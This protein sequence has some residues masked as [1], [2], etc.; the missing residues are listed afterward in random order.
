MPRAEQL[1]DPLTEHGE[2]PVWF[3][4]PRELRWVD[5]LAGDVMAL[6]AVA[7]VTRRH[8]GTV[9][10]A[11][12]P[13]S[14]GGFVVALERCFALDDGDGSPL[15]RLPPLWAD[16]GVRMNEGACDP[17]GRFYCGSM[18]YDQTPRTGA[19]YRLDPD[20]TV[21]VVL[22]GCSISNG[23]D[24]SPDG[25]T[26]YYVDTPTQR[27]DT[28]DYSTSGSLEDRRTLV[29]IPAESGAPDGL[30]VDGEGAIWVA[31]WGG[32]AVHRYLPDGILDTVITLPVS[33]VTACTIGG[34]SLDCLYIT[35]SRIGLPAG[36]EPEAGSVFQ[37]EHVP[38]GRTTRPFTG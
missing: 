12:R 11:L 37:V 29:N 5:M 24:W 26:A 22:Q 6:D 4:G 25:S 16:P 38:G 18:A 23:L 21:H 36:A 3:D 10:A 19:M 31:L 8:V 15:R 32:S 13:R 33:Q 35:T 7:A 17:H 9:A 28:F 30:T 2:G 20:G 27:I 34:A 14:Q 1:T